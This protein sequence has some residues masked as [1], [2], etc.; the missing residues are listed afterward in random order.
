M[1]NRELNRS[2]KRLYK[3]AVFKRMTTHILEA[4]IK[5]EFLNLYYLDKGFERFNKDSILMLI[6]INLRHK[7]MPVEKL[8][9]DINQTKLLK[10]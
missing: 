1:N 3:R 4:E 9:S 10:I 7:F 8:G 5:P 6:A 2:V